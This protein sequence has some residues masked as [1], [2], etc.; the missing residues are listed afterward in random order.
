[1]KTNMKFQKLSALLLLVCLLGGCAG[2]MTKPFPDTENG[3]KVGVQRHQLVWLGMVPPGTTRFEKNIFF[4]NFYDPQPG[5]SDF[6]WLLDAMLA[7]PGNIPEIAGRLPEGALDE[8]PDLNQT[9]D[10]CLKKEMG[11]APTEDRLAWM[12]PTYEQVKPDKS[13]QK[14]LD[15]WEAQGNH[16][17]KDYVLYSPTLPLSDVR[18]LPYLVF[19]FVDREKARLWT[20]LMV[21]LVDQPE[22]DQGYLG[23]PKKNPDWFCRYA[24]TDG[25][26]RPLAGDGGWFGEGSNA[27][28]KTASQEMKNAVD[29]LLDDL[30]GKLRSDK[31]PVE[32]INGK[33][34]F[35]FKPRQVDA[36]ILRKTETGE[37]V[38]PLVGDN[39]YFGGVNILPANFEEPSGK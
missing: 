19:S 23:N 15:K 6:F 21:V 7:G 30:H 25:V 28:K 16:W 37:V 18:I 3:L 4:S 35:Y 14:L 5:G 13:I 36:R 32:K 17:I 8:I 22:R 9:A 2:V 33:W 12:E 38:V 26:A 1:M 27:V 24:A 39:E 34:L 29:V 31:A 11:L 20:V 10:D